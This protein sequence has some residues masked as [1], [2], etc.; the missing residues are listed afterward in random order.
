MQLVRCEKCRDHLDEEDLFCPNCGSEAPGHA[1]GHQADPR[2]Q[3]H[4][5]E[6]AGCGATL[7]W[8][9]AVQALR[10]SFCGRASLEEKPPVRMPAPRLVAPF[11]IDRSQ[12]EVILRQWLGRGYLRPNDLRDAS[13]LTEIRSVFLPFWSFT[14]QCDTYWTAD[15]NHLPPGAKA[16]WAPQFGTH[17]E[18]VTVFLPASGVLTPSEIGK[19]GPFQIAEAVPYAPELLGDSPTEAFG[20]TRKQARQLAGGQLEELLKKTCTD[21]VPGTRSRNVHLNPLYTGTTAEPVLLPVWILAYEY[22]DR[23]FRFLVNGQTGIAE[24]TAPVSTWKVVF[25]IL[26][27]ALLLLLMLLTAIVSSLFDSFN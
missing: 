10:C 12:A 9:I 18:D 8:E 15:S 14:V 2:I 16:E 4:R 11:R 20:K 19:L 1:K 23:I 5:F 24:G 7:V 25:T 22:R 27:P 13:R 17:Q 6:C 21:L 3:V 26:L